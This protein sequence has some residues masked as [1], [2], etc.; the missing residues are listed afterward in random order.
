MSGAAAVSGASAAASG[1]GGGGDD[2]LPA[3][4]PPGQQKQKQQQRRGGGGCQALEDLALGTG[5]LMGAFL[6][7][8][9]GGLLGGCWNAGW[10]PSWSVHRA[11]GDGPRLLVEGV[12]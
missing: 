7:G 9:D 11:Q 5:L 3:S 12:C 4:C 6:V 10:G 1:C 2:A 8:A